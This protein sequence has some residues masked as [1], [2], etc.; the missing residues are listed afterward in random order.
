MKKTVLLLTILFAS[1]TAW[2]QPTYK[3]VADK[4]V[5]VV[6]DKIVLQSDIDNTI[7]DMERQGMPLPENPECMIMEQAMAMKALMLQAE[8]DSLFV[9][10]D[11]IDAMIENQ[12]RGFIAAYGSKEELERVAGRTIYQL[13]EDFR[14]NF[15]ERR[16]AE[17]MRNKIVD[18]I[19]IT[20]QEVRAYFESI[21]P[22]SL[23]LYESELEIGQIVIYPKASRDVEEY[24]IE[25]L[26]EIKKQAEAGRDFGVLANMHTEDGGSR[27]RGGLYEINRTQRD[28]DPVW[29]SKAF[30]LK[31]GQISMP[32]K[33]KFGYHIIKL[34]S[35]YGDDAVVRHILKIPKVTQVEIREGLQKLDSIRAQLITGNM[36]FGTAV[37]KY[38]EDEMS[39]FTGGWIN[40]RNGNFVAIDELDKS[41]IPILTDLKVGE[42]SQPMEFMDERGRRA[43]RLIYLK[44]KTDPHVENL[45]DDYNR[46]A[47]RA[48]E[49]KKEKAIDDWFEN[50]VK[51][52]YI[53]VDERYQNCEVL[54][55]W[56]PAQKD[57]Q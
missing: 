28:L 8:K 46:I 42:Y 1:I 9:S 38:S 33:T 14:T 57:N 50:R 41:M 37:S 56:L 18:N 40:G 19:R 26:N 16:L 47:Q 11:E 17:N 54:Q 34:E 45:K 30:T 6:G 21:P 4:V 39:K 2:A 49:I 24:T 53:R 48:L 22:D 29:L 35:R 23:P 31:E 25:Q 43:V 51:Q 5:A 7:S 55:K 20:P 3:V 32:F 10:D 27:D 13:K 44:T 52:F 15:R 36:D 12:I